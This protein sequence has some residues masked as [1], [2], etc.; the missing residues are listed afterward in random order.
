MSALETDAETERLIARMLME[1]LS[2][3]E[4]QAAAESFQISHAMET[5]MKEAG[6]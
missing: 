1:D 2:L 6:E 5:S 4:D 3:L